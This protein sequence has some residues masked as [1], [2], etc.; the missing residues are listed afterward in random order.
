[1]HVDMA[2]K[3][4][5]AMGRVGPGRA[6]QVLGWAGQG[7]GRVGQGQPRQ[8]RTE[9]GGA[10]QG[11]AGEWQNREGYHRK[12]AGQGSAVQEIR[13]WVC[14]EYTRR[15]KKGRAGHGQTG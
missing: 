15:S 1:M 11:S 4:S 9:Q 6:G 5:A 14:I 8:T 2:G 12:E 7:L 3:G 13:G 10:G